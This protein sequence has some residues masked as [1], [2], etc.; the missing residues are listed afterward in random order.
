[1]SA[2]LAFQIYP[3]GTSKYRREIGNSEIR[4]FDILRETLNMV[5]GAFCVIGVH[6]ASSQ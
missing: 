6:C 1:M 5:F 4:P 2:G 3:I